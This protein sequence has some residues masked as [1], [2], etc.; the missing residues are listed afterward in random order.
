VM[1]RSCAYSI[2][3]RMSS[4]LPMRRG[5]YSD[6]ADEYKPVWPSGLWATSQGGKTYSHQSH[7]DDDDDD[8]DDAV[9]ALY[10]GVRHIHA[11][12]VCETMCFHIPPRQ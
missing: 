6:D 10:R 3:W 7:A 5:P 12:H 11:N 9:G 2:R 1:M 8:D 4:L